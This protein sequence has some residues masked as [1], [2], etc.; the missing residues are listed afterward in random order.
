[1]FFTKGAILSLQEIKGTF[2]FPREGQ[3][4]GRGYPL[5]GVHLGEG[6]LEP[7]LPRHPVSLIRW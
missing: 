7:A 5:G 4:E 1:M 3:A 2:S 6:E